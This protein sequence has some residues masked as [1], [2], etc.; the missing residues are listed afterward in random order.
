MVA[1]LLS[2]TG[3]HPRGQPAPGQ[4]QRDCTQVSFVSMG[5]FSVFT[6]HSVRAGCNLRPQP[7]TAPGLLDSVPRRVPPMNGPRPEYLGWVGEV[8]RLGP[9]PQ[10]EKD[11]SMEPNVD[12]FGGTLARVPH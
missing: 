10:L 4:H 11:M 12:Q 7:E 5:D 6:G 1:D 8:Q 2:R 3:Q 9:R